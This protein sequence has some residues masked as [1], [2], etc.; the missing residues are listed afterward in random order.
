MKVVLLEKMITDIKNTNE[1]NSSV[2]QQIKS[3]LSKGNEILF[4]KVA[5]RVNQ[6]EQEHIYDSESDA[7]QENDKDDNIIA[8][9]TWSATIMDKN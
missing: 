2:V 6:N 1:F 4:S 9:S 8:E 3:N 5:Y 7:D